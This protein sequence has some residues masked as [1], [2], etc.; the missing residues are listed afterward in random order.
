MNY[1]EWK[2]QA[3]PEGH[4]EPE[5]IKCPLCWDIVNHDELIRYHDKEMNTTVLGCIKCKQYNDENF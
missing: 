2:L 3:A 5:T 4:E 1:D